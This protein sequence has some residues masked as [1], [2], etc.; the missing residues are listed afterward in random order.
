MLVNN[1]VNSKSTQTRTQLII[2]TDNC[3]MMF[4]LKNTNCKLTCDVNV[5]TCARSILSSFEIQWIRCINYS[6][7]DCKWSR[8]TAN[9]ILNTTKASFW[10]DTDVITWKRNIYCSNIFDTLLNRLSNQI[11]LEK[12]SVILVEK[13]IV[14]WYI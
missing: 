8:I 3:N 9:L 4:M 5:I 11:W 2:V 6:R 10:T 1:P 14:R 7:S 12:C 13:N